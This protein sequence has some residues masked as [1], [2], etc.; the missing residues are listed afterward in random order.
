MDTLMVT[1]LLAILSS[2]SAHEPFTSALNQLPQACLVF[3]GS[4]KPDSRVTDDATVDDLCTKAKETYPIFKEPSFALL[5]RA[6]METILIQGGGI[7]TLSAK[8]TQKGP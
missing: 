5:N 3:L 7:K 6:E 1:Q 2:F 4:H 8:L